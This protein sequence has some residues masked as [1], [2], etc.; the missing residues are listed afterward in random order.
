MVVKVTYFFVLV[1]LRMMNGRSFYRNLLAL[2]EVPFNSSVG[3][4]N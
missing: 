3:D 2:Q 4:M 1:W